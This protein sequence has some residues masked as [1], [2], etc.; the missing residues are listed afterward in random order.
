MLL[1]SVSDAR[2]CVMTY[3]RSRQRLQWFLVGSLVLLAISL[4]AFSINLELAIRVYSPGWNVVERLL[5]HGLFVRLSPLGADRSLVSTGVPVMLFAFPLWHALRRRREL[6]LDPAAV[7]HRT[8][9]YPEH[10]PFFCVM[11]GLFGTLYGMMIG[12]GSSGVSQLATAAPTS[13]SIRTAL[14]RLLSGTATALLSS[15]VGMVGAFLAA[16]PF[17][18]AL[19]RWCTGAS[20]EAEDGDLIVVVAQLTAELQ[21]LAQ[22]SAEAR[23]G[24]GG[25]AAGQILAR[26]DKLQA[27]AESSANAFAAI[28]K[29]VEA[30]ASG[31]E[32][33]AARLVEGLQAI[34]QSSAQTASGID[35]LVRSEP[36]H[37]EA[38]AA[39]SASARATAEQL[40]RLGA[41]AAAQHQAA[42][43]EWKGLREAAGRQAEE[44]GR[45]RA[46][47][48]RALASYA[49]DAREP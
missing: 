18:P 20:D 48:R 42:L 13:E 15:I 31:Q 30:L 2:F 25:D 44:S 26:L 28:H 45:D 35:A 7:S 17:L 47:L 5:S 4:F 6:R 34:Q 37:R 38:L 41:D 22:A 3:I 33:T 10:F 27:A 46:A 12:L 1:G 8:D 23:K 49:G 19:Y 14:D 40:G 29:T 16:Q 32:Q 39:V 43:A 24:W 9:P 36:A 21:A 11:L